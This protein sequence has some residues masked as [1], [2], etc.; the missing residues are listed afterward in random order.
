MSVSDIG[1]VTT[2]IKIYKSKRNFK[3]HTI[4]LMHSVISLLQNMN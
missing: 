4:K 3:V 1:T 2:F